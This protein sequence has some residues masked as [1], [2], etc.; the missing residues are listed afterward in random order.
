MCFCSHKM[1]EGALVVYH[2]VPELRSGWEGS[3]LERGQSLF[4]A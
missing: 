1:K 2:K 4:T 3:Y